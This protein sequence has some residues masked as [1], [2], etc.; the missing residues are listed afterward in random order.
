MGYGEQETADWCDRVGDLLRRVVRES[1]SRE[2]IFELNQK[3]PAGREHREELNTKC[4]G[5]E[6]ARTKAL[7][8]E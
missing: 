2:V 6:T 8:L 7:G 1:L 3:E 4:K 5:T